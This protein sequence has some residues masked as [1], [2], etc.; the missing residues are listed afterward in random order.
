MICQDELYDECIWLILY[1][2]AHLLDCL[3]TT[4]HLTFST[5]WVYF[6][7]RSSGIDHPTY[8]HVIDFL[9]L[10]LYIYIYTACIDEI[11]WHLGRE[12]I[13]PWDQYEVNEVNLDISWV[14]IILYRHSL[15]WWLHV[16]ASGW[17]TAHAVVL[18]FQYGGRVGWAGILMFMIV[19]V[20]CV[21]R[22]M[23]RC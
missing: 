16:F 14:T 3:S 15:P 18:L 23:L 21:H 11:S 1:V 12:K 17:K 9:S 8:L 2:Y 10:S 19:H 7:C 13:V 6:G 20:P 4:H 5:I 22:W